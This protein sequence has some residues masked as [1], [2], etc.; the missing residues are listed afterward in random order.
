MLLRRLGFELRPHPRSLG[1]FGELW[2]NL[3]A[4][5]LMA[6][7]NPRSVRGRSPTSLQRHDLWMPMEMFLRRYALTPNPPPAERERGRG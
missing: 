6:V 2:K 7:F 1:A 3:Y 5:G 4:L